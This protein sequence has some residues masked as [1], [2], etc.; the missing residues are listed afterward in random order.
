LLEWGM[1]MKP[2][3]KEARFWGKSEKDK[4]R[5]GL[6]PHECVIRENK[7]GICKNKKNINGVLYAHRYGEITAI[8]MDPIEKKPLYHFH[9]GEEILSVGTFGCNLSCS[10]CQ[11]YHLWAGDPR[12]DYADPSQ[13]IAIAKRERSFAIAYTYNEP[14]MSYEYVMDTAV[15]AKEAGLKNVMVTNGHYNEE[16]FEKLLPFI[17][18]MNIDLK[19]MDPDFYKKLCKGKLD[20]VKK[21]IERAHNDCLIEITNLIITGENDLDKDFEE[22]ADYIASIDKNIPLHFSAYRPMYKMKNPSTPIE[23]L[24]SA[25]KIASEKL[26]YVYL[27]NVAMDKG[28]DSACPHCGAILVKRLGYSARIMSLEDKSCNECGKALN[29]VS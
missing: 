9:P 22:I 16:P 11:N 17:D 10:F 28:A 27:G 2:E 12:T 3:M 1:T 24:E 4:V 7:E 23:R 13:I 8:G 21:T 19:S 29:F 14:Y 18:A 25:F 15:L 6:C 20:P 26:N 5:C